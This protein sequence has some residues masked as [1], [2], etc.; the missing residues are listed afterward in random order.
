MRQGEILAILKASSEPMTVR[1]ILEAHG[2]RKNRVDSDMDNIRKH[3]ATMLKRGEVRRVGFVQC[4]DGHLR[5]TW[6][7]VE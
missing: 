4:D 5:L 2:I 6:E 7:A 3:L 1:Q